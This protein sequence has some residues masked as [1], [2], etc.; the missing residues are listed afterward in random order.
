[1]RN[2]PS[3]KSQKGL[4]NLELLV[5]ESIK[6]I[7]G[8]VKTGANLYIEDSLWKKYHDTHAQEI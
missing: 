6:T 1:M 3:L 8:K 2:S 5:P 7:W 4:I